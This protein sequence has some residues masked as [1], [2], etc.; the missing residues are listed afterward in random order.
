MF[1]N[2]QA[3]SLQIKCRN[4]TNMLNSVKVA[5]TLISHLASK[6]FLKACNKKKLSMMCLLLH[7]ETQLASSC[8][9]AHNFFGLFNSSLSQGQIFHG[10]SRRHALSQRVTTPGPFLFST[11]LQRRPV[12]ISAI[13]EENASVWSFARLSASP[14]LRQNTFVAFSTHLSFSRLMKPGHVQQLG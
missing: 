4:N 7:K 10:N 11:V 14:T 9:Q 12:S 6:E 13:L 8:R 3:Y 1:F 2:F 5:S